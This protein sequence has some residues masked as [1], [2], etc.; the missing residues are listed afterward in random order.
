MVA[1]AIDQPL[2]TLKQEKRTSLLAL[3]LMTVLEVIETY[4]LLPQLLTILS[5]M[6]CFCKW[7]E[8]MQ[9]PPRFPRTSLRPAEKTWFEK[10]HD[11]MIQYAAR[12]PF[13]RWAF[14]D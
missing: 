2:E 12:Q 11:R 3:I 5:T 9:E 10:R 7:V 1:G 14:K 6:F 4:P 13:L 8:S